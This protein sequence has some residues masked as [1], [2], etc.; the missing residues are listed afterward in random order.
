M[1]LDIL[2]DQPL[3]KICTGYEFRGA[4]YDHPIANISHYKHCIPIYEEM[5][6]WQTAIGAATCW[7]DLP[8][9]CRDYVERIGELIGAPIQLVATGPRRDSRARRRAQRRGWRGEG[10]SE[11]R[12]GR[13]RDR[14]DDAEICLALSQQAGS[15]PALHWH[16]SRPV[17]DDDQSHHRLDRG[18]GQKGRF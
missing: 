9:A 12:L 8:Q 2:D 5:P 10:R 4:R 11:R 1:R 14:L 15:L 6:G 7:E 18:H 3:L 16:R 17:K 13:V